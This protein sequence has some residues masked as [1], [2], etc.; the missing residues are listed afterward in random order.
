[1]TA[2][3][4]SAA[5]QQVALLTGASSGIAKAAA[6]ALANA[7]YRVIGTSRDASGEVRNGIRMIAC[8]VTSWSRP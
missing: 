8:D 2:N 3:H 7:G 5:M 6:A 4:Q 1:M